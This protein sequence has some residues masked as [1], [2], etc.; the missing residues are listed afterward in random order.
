M[1]IKFS[2]LWPHLCLIAILIPSLASAA[3]TENAFNEG[4]KLYRAGKYKNAIAAFDRAVKVA[5]KDAEAY[6]HRGLFQVG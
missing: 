5:P 6:N 1:P 2:R 4:V 3:T